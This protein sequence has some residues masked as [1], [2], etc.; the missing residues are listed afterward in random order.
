MKHIILLLSLLCLIVA[1]GPKLT[2]QGSKVNIGNDSQLK[3]CQLLGSTRLSLTATRLKFTK[4][5]AIK[6]HL[7]ID[8]RNFAARIGGNMV[9]PVGAIEEGKQSFKIYN[10]PIFDD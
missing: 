3:Q 2:L 9:L 6:E 10:C 7:I 5:D 8:A 1:C 4:E